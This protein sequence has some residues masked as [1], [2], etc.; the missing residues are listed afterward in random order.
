MGVSLKT[1]Q[2][3]Q[4]VQ[5]IAVGV[6]TAALQYAHLTTLQAAL[7]SS[8]LSDAIQGASYHLYKTLK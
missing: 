6:V 3:L 2:N 4:F 5:N 1:F 8:R 7:A